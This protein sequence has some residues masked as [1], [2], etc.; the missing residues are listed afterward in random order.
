MSQQ[1]QQ[2]FD[3]IDRYAA[4]Q[5]VE[6]YDAQVDVRDQIEAKLQELRSQFLEEVAAHFDSRG[7]TAEGGW[8]AGYY[9]VD[10]PGEIVRSLKESPCG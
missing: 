5:G 2:L 4:M 10:E 8:S 7:K 6:P 1:I 9:E 3:L